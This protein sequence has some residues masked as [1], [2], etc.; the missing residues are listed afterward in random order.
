MSRREPLVYLG[1]SAEERA[2]RIVGGCPEVEI[3]QAIVRGQLRFSNGE[4]VISGPGWQATAV[5][6]EGVLRPRPRAWHVTAITRTPTTR[7]EE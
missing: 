7:T 3:A 4:A 1:R 2:R 6:T 5:R